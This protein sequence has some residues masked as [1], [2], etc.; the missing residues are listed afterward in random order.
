LP[1]VDPLDLYDVRALLDDDERLVKDNVARFVD[2]DVRPIIDDCFAEERFPAELVPRLAELGLF[3][4]T[5]SGYGCAGLN[6]TSYGLI[7]EELERGDS[8]LR[9]CVSVQ[10]SLV[11]GCIDAFGSDEQKA[12]WLPA[13]A[14]GTSLGCFALTEAHGGSDPARMRT[15]AQRR[16]GDWVLNGAKLWITNGALADVSIVWAVAD[17]RIAA[18]LVERGTPG[19]E[20]REIRDKFSL[21]ASSTAEISLMDVRVPAAS[22][23]PGAEG[24]KAALACLDHARFGIA[25]GAIGAAR[26][27]LAAVLAHVADRELF[28]RKLARTQLIQS[29]LADSAR[30]ITAAQ[31]LAWRLARLKDAGGVAGVQVS[32]AKWNN[33]RMALDVARDCRD[34]LGAAGITLARSPIRHM[35]NLESVSTYE[36]TE[37]IHR[38][39]VG[40][41]LTGENAF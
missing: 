7:C 1:F 27:C 28:G 17:E 15:R 33:V 4:A 41:E 14:R 13:L 30:R 8:S 25:W 24:L 12:R 11:M 10:S 18:F 40:R 35:L 5:L 6:Y 39:V 20:A 32:L 16:N 9:S 2:R 21:R 31:L 36:G 23:L 19:L 38:L 37:A 3:G 26:D 34:M 22:R 29:R